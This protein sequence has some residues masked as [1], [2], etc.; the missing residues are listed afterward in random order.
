MENTDMSK[1]RIGLLVSGRGS[2]LRTL[3]RVCG[4]GSLP[5]EVVAVASNRECPALDLAREAGVGHVASYLITDYASRT[6]RDARIAADL[7][8][9]D[10]TF[11][12]VGGY[13]EALEPEFFD[14]VPR[15]TISMYPALLPAFGELDEAIGPALDA[16]VKTIGVTIHFRTPLSVS[17]GP[18][19]AQEPLPVDVGDTVESVTTRVIALE[20]QFLPRVLRAF[21]E[22]RVVREGDRV[23]VID[24]AER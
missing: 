12:V 16:G 2:V 10:V 9:A 17:A 24:A 19:I 4:D 8:R 22:G 1:L 7:V 3:L 23:K 13:S 18:I 20:S 6:E 14:G 11:V 5:G 21:C 15:D